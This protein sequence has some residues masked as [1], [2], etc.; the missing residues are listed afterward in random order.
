MTTTKG[1]GGG[2]SYKGRS[3]KTGRW[4][5]KRSDAVK[6]SVRAREI[7]GRF[8]AQGRHFSDSADLVREDRDAD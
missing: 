7:R 8:R 3:D 4:R 1:R 5:K 2:G 6:A